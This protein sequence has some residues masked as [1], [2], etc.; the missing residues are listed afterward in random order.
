MSMCMKLLHIFIYTT[1]IQEPEKGRGIQIRVTGSCSTPNLWLGTKTGTFVRKVHSLNCWAIFTTQI[2]YPLCNDL[3]IL[4][5]N[6]Q[7]LL[8]ESY[9]CH[10]QYVEYILSEEISSVSNVCKITDYEIVK[11]INLMNDLNLMMLSLWWFK[12]NIYWNS[13]KFTHLCLL[14]IST[15]DFLK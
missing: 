13:S 15:M 1:C 2:L 3:I 8:I 4:I 12:V 6:K 9:F 11:Y 7:F 10:R 5:K 14:S